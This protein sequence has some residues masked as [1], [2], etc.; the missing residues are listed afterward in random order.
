MKF[1]VIIG[2]PPYQLSTGE[3]TSQAIPLYN[4]FVE[5]SLELNPKYITMIIPSRWMMGGIG[6]NSFREKMIADKRISYMI[7]YENS[8]DIFPEVNIDGG[9]CYFLW[10]YKHNGKVNHS[11]ISLTGEK[12]HSKRYLKVDYHDK[13]IRD[14]RQLS[15][16]KKVNTTK[17]KRFSRLVSKDAYRM[18]SYLFSSPEKISGVFLSD[19]YKDGFVKIYGNIG[20]AGGSKRT[21]KY[22]NKD[23]IKN[24]KDSINKYKMFFSKAYT[25]TATVPPEIIMGEPGEICTETFLKVGDFNSKEEMNNALSYIKTKFFRALLSYNRNSLNVTVESFSLIPLQDFSKPW[26]DEELYKKYKLTQEEIDYIEEKIAP[27]STSDD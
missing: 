27:M 12:I 18:K 23:S 24:N 5:K 2:N 13:V 15:I 21:H 22:I 19:S 26:T 14:P 3:G 7:D 8:S 1:D 4:K 17:G 6:L 9:V 11:F 25:M 10:D 20:K 16:I